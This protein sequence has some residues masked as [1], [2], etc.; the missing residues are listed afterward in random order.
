MR[1][2]TAVVT[3]ASD[4]ARTRAAQDRPGPAGTCAAAV[5][6]VADV[7]QTAISG[8]LVVT[9]LTST[10]RSCTNWGRGRRGGRRIGSGAQGVVINAGN[11]RRAVALPLARI[12]VEVEVSPKLTSLRERCLG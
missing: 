7:A 2:A 9:I 10:T 5:V 1:K 8:A 11:V 12:A 6:K 3:S 4:A